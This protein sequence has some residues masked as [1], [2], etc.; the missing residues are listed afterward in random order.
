MGAW[1]AALDNAISIRGE[2]PSFIRSIEQSDG[3]NRSFAGLRRRGS[4]A[5]ALLG[6]GIKRRSQ[7]SVQRPRPPPAMISRMISEVPA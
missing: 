4:E 5:E 1:I 7:R 3:A 2:D 6:C